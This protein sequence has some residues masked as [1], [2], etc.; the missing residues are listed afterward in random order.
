MVEFGLIQSSIK[1]QD[2]YLDYDEVTEFTEVTPELEM[3][4]K[5]RLNSNIRQYI[6]PHNPYSQYQGRGE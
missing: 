5:E 6:S 4:N 3:D 2:F 1:F